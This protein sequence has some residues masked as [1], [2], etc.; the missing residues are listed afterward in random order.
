MMWNVF[1]ACETVLYE[2]LGFRRGAG[3]GLHS[4]GAWGHVTGWSVPAVA[5]QRGG[6]AKGLSRRVLDIQVY[7]DI[8]KRWAPHPL[9]KRR[10]YET[11][12]LMWTRLL[13]ELGQY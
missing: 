4:S 1:G 3:G 8:S 2:F 13:S 7:E 9:K 10:P 11:A 12:V 5:I 6:L